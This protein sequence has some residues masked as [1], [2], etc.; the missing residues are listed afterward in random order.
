[1]RI[2]DELDRHRYLS[3]MTFRVS[4]AEVRTPV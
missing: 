1:L 4:G 2:A 3:L